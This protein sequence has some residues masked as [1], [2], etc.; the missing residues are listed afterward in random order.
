MPQRYGF[1]GVEGPGE[2][3]SAAPGGMVNVNGSADRSP[4]G[5]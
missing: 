4:V 5:R 3:M 2:I 1:T